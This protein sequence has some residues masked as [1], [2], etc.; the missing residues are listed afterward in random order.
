VLKSVDHLDLNKEQSSPEL[1]SDY[2]E[3]SARSLGP[4]VLGP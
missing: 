1:I 4:G 2:G 3:Q